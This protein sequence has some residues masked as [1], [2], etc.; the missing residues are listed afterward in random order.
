VSCDGLGGTCLLRKQTPRAGVAFL[1][2]R[3]RAILADDMGL[4][5]SRTAIIALREADSAGPYL[6]IC[7]AG[8]KLTWRYEN[9]WRRRSPP[10]RSRERI[11]RTP[12]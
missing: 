7:P 8:V 12:A 1:L 4:G 11:P 3:R 5:K 9:G 2:S 6:I 10:A